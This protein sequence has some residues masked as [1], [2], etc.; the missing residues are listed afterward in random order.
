MG[1]AGCLPYPVHTR[2]LQILHIASPASLPVAHAPLHP[3]K[4]HTAAC[5][6]QRG[7]AAL[8][9]AVAEALLGP[10]A[11]EWEAAA[12]LE[13]SC[14]AALAGGAGGGEAAAQVL[15]DAL[16]VAKAG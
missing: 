15:L 12:G 4:T 9:L 8:G 3:L 5:V 6:K 11:A 7:V 2:Q 16:E 1:L 13:R 14:L 10:G